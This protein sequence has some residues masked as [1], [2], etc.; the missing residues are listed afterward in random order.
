MSYLDQTGRKNP[1][2]IAAVVGVHLA[3]GYALLIGLGYTVIHPPRPHG[4]VINVPNDPPPPPPRAE[5]TPRTHQPTNVAPPLPKPDDLIADKPIFKPILSDGPTG[6]TDSGGGGTVVPTQIEPARPSQAVDA[7]PGKDRLR[8]ITTDD[9]PPGLIRQN[10]QGVVVISVMIGTD[11]K[12]RS[13]LV[14]Q[15]SGNQQLDDTTC[16]LYAKRA[17]FTP[18]RDADGNP[19]SAQRTDR[20]RWQT[21]TE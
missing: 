4:G 6:T 20:Y 16:R 5:P 21:P 1:A 14:T 10:V 13:C 7:Q 11:G 18:A 17:H 8:W 3:V 19:T 9:Y 12:I 15:T 2:S